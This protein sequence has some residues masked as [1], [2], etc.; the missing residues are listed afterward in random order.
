[1]RKTHRQTDIQNDII[2]TFLYYREGFKVP[3]G[4]SYATI[5]SKIVSEMSQ[6]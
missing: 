6:M 5:G 2:K 4:E 3:S 1:M